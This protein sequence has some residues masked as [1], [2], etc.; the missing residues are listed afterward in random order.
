M[1]SMLLYLGL[2]LCA[3]VQGFAQS[4]EIQAGHCCDFNAVDE[5]S[6]YN[7]NQITHNCIDVSTLPQ[8]KSSSQDNSMAVNQSKFI[9]KKLTYWKWQKAL[10]DSES[11]VKA[12]V[13][14]LSRNHKSVI[15]NAIM[16]GKGSGTE[17]AIML[18]SATQF[19]I[20]L[21]K[22]TMTIDTMKDLD[23]H[24]QAAFMIGSKPV[25]FISNLAKILTSRTQP[26]S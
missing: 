25:K 13:S 9:G 19:D 7:L 10:L 18:N 16:I 20:N 1:K 23:G 17:V 11:T 24:L 6:N 8:S 12:A 4:G 5:I 21:D 15:S 22:P 26:N 3:H 14:N 2:W